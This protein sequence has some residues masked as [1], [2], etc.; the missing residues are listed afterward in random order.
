MANNPKEPQNK[1]K[2]GS[3]K[4]SPD[5]LDKTQ[6]DVDLRKFEEEDAKSSEKTPEKVSNADLLDK[7]QANIDLREMK[8]ALDETLIFEAPPLDDEDTDLHRLR[9]QKE[10][11]LA[12]KK[13]TAQEEVKA[14]AQ[15]FAVE[16]TTSPSD[17]ENSSQISEKSSKGTN[18][19]QKAKHLWKELT[20]FTNI[21]PPPQSRFAKIVE[22]AGGSILLLALL[23]VCIEALASASP[24]VP[25]S[26]AVVI[27]S[28][29]VNVYFIIR[30]GNFYAGLEVS[31]WAFLGLIGY[32]TWKYGGFDSGAFSLLKS[33]PSQVYNFVFL[34]ILLLVLVLV[35]QNKK[36]SWPAKIVLTVFVVFGAAGFIQNL[37]AWFFYNRV[38]NLEDTLY[39]TELWRWLPFYYF[40]PVAFS[41]WILFPALT[42]YFLFQKTT[43][44]F[45]KE[46]SFARE[47]SLALGLV[48]LSL[49]LGQLILFKNRY[50]SVL[51]FV[52]P[53]QTGWGQARAWNYGGSSPE[54]YDIEVST[55]NTPVDK[56][57]DAVSVYRLG[58]LFMASG[59]SKKLINLSLRG[60]GG[61]EIPFLKSNDI[62]VFQEQVQ[63]KPIKVKAR[64][65]AFLNRKSLVFLIDRS[66]SMSSFI[67]YVDK[68]GKSLFEMLNSRE[69]FYWMPFSESSQATLI[70]DLKTMRKSASTLFAQ[71]ARNIPS[72]IEKAI[73]QVKGQGGEKVILMVSTQDSVSDDLSR[74]VTLL[75][76]EKIKFYGANFGEFAPESLKMLAEGS[77]GKWVS[78]KSP[79]NLSFALRSLVADAFAQYQ[80]AYEGQSFSPKFTILNPQ[81]GEDVSKDSLLQVKIQNFQDVR[82]SLAR[83]Y[84][85]GKLIQ[86]LPIQGA[87]ISFPLSIVQLPKGAH[88]FKVAL[89]GEGGREF[90]EEIKLN[91]SAISDFAFIRPLEGDVVSG[92]VSL[93]VY[94]KSRLQNT[95][96]KVEFLVDSQKVGEASSEP[97]LFTWDSQGLNGSHVIQAIATFADGSTLSDQI[98]INVATGFGIKIGS[99]ALGEFLNNLTE[100]EADVTHNLSEI[101]NKVEFLV[102]G[103][104][105]GEVTQAP[106]KYLWDN[107]ELASGKHVLQARAYNANN[108]VSTDAVV[109]NIGNGSLSVQLADSPSPYLAPDYIEWVIDASA[110]MN[111]EVAGMKKIDLVKQSLLDMLPK[112]PP[113]SQLAIRS[114][115][116]NSLSSHNNCKDSALNYPLKAVESQKVQAALNGIEAQGMSP[117][118]YALDKLR[119]D[120][121]SATGTRVVIL[122]TDGFDNC[123][124][125]PV[126]Q[127]ERWKKEKL[128]IKLYILGLDVEGSRSETEL[129]RL[130][131]IVGGQYYSVKNEKEILNALEEMVKVTY[132]VFDYKDREVIQRPIGAPSVSLRTGEYR[133]ELD[134][135]PPLIKSK[136][137]INNGVEKKLLLR[138]E[139]NGYSFS[140]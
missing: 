62:A 108:W 128:N 80:I 88:V 1:G 44:I 135:E 14:K 102:D 9:K 11:E 133:L 12:E 86:E 78:V 17:F 126:G 122:I 26:V 10:L 85:D 84:L 52:L 6:L 56:N 120:L 109:V 2:S 112:M 75:K 124:S 87:E 76:K 46:K 25:L 97:Y 127:L 54:D 24:L 96:Q 131:A 130:A 101:I 95:I 81:A 18:A 74:F 69:S 82:L 132:R 16:P 35:Y 28:V 30:K 45:N 66:S 111:A 58:A 138:K 123:A 98:K 22:F 137:L 27:L 61:V 3:Q 140:E 65:E 79:P 49:C 23:D 100:I 89:V 36:T 119:S 47:S 70:K 68:A 7:T 73:A 134:L 115:G 118:G 114:F 121:R 136:V 77:G 19:K 60:L 103:T 53:A 91:V 55:A 72:A 71:G 29:L 106:Y 31:V 38:W 107:S 139:A 92:Q 15:E 57:N 48:F 59:D 63:Q 110:S 117:I 4:P 129:K 67:P 116:A 8:V 64:D 125:D 94:Y 37:S 32:S 39:G 42:L 41:F 34:F 51:S 13:E 21:A 105:L 83:L 33:S 104:L 20:N 5:D 43:D 50:P 99:P 90:N 93:E 40:R 113:S